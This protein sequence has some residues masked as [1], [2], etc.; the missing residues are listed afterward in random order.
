VFTKLFTAAGA[1]LMAA[2]PT[3]A[4]TV[5]GPNPNSSS[6]V[7]A[8]DL[9][10]N[11]YTG[12]AELLIVRSDLGYGV[13]EGCSGTLLGDGV[14]ILTSAHCIADVNG[15]E[16]ATA[17]YVTFTTAD[18]AYTA[19]AVSFKVDPA[20]N[21]SSNSPNDV[22]V[23]TLATPAPDY[24]ERYGLYTGNVSDQS[25]T[26]AGYGFGGTGV[27]GYDPRQYPFGTPRVVENQRQ[28]NS[29][30]DDL[31]FDFSDPPTVSDEGGPTFIDGEIAGV[32]SYVIDPTGTLLN[33]S[34]G[35]VG[36]DASVASNI[37]FIESAMLPAPEPKLMIVLGLTLVAIALSGGKRKH[38]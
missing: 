23:L 2:G 32:H 5:S 30:T 9:Y 24:L 13:V 29:A 7:A 21:G 11:P 36:A 28:P 31:M 10:G 16:R 34:F 18:G 17:A 4:I 27:T 38:R 35:E 26:L 20:F 14:S 3:Y 1:F 12:V 33:S 6:Y 8:A 19:Q 22:A 37:A 15:V 25:I